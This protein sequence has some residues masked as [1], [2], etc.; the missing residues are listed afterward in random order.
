M[1]RA[2]LR[3]RAFTCP[4]HAVP[5]GQY[6][7]PSQ[8]GEAPRMSICCKSTTAVRGF[9][10]PK[11]GARYLCIPPLLAEAPILMPESTTTLLATAI[12]NPWMQSKIMRE[13]WIRASGSAY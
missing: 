8:F 3:D 5:D 13:T 6:G 1:L 2:Q 9:I 7:R 12:T 4:W 10:G 11:N